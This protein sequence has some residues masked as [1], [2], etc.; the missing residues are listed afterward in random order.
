[1]RLI[2]HRGRQGAAAENSIS[3]LESLPAGVAGVEVDV[4]V[5]ADHVPILMHDADLKRTTNG[6]GLV[7][8]ASFARIRDLSLEGA[9]EPPP[10][11]EDYL[12]RADEHLRID[13][14]T[15][16]GGPPPDIYLDIKTSDKAALVLIARTISELPFVSRIVC[17]SRRAADIDAIS[18]AGARRLRLGL[19]GCNKRNVAEAMEIAGDYGL[20]VLFVQHGLEGF[21]E[22]VGILPVIL[23]AGLQAGGSI[24]NGSRA[25]EYARKKG[26][27]LVLTDLPPSRPKGAPSIRKSIA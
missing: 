2:A 13:P 23:A 22:N 12:R 18:A 19:L 14:G 9:N 8:E 27:S 17:L 4:R 1:M 11:M 6:L 26:C 24:L 3:G 5:T 7:E 16:A 20:E 15:A 21:R 25:L 10:R